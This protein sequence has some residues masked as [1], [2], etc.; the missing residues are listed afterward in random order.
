MELHPD[1]LQ[2]SVQQN[3][4]EK[5]Y[6]ERVVIQFLIHWYPHEIQKL[7]KLLLVLFCVWAFSPGTSARSGEYRYRFRYR[8]R[9]RYKLLT[10]LSLL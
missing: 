8:Y 2:N 6:E 1:L 4:Q 10:N 7:S 3:N 9:Y 5:H